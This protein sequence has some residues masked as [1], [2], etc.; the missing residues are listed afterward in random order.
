MRSS[1]PGTLVTP[2]VVSRRSDRT[3]PDG[4]A[5][6]RGVEHA[7]FEAELRLDGARAEEHGYQR[8]YGDALS[9]GSGRETRYGTE[10]PNTSA[11]LAVLPPEV[12][13]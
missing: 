9:H 4:V 10:K 1:D 11:A 12:E 2:S 5:H 13:K 6:A 8:W 3:W 7:G